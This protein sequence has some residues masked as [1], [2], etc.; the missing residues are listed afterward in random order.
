MSINQ[1]RLAV[2]EAQW[3]RKSPDTVKPTFDFL[4]QFHHDSHAFWYER[5]VGRDSFKEALVW[6]SSR[7]EVRY[8]Y[9]ATHGEGEHLE[10]PNGERVSRMDIKR[11]LER[12]LGG[13]S[14][15]GLYFGSCLFLTSRNAHYLLSSSGKMSWLA[16]YEGNIDFIKSAALDL[17]FWHLMLRHSNLTV[18]ARIAQVAGEL[19]HNLGGLID[20]LGFSIYVRQQGTGELVDLMQG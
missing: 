3:W 12:G 19:K 5:F 15:D 17:M 11:C 8:V 6:L 18:R 14:L 9:I 4:S 10:C 1:F 20:E 2:L 13:S 16:G 7:G